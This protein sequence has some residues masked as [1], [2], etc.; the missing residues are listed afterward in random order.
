MSKYIKYDSD[1]KKMIIET[2]NPNL[3]PELNIPRTITL[4]W[5]EKADNF[6]FLDN[7]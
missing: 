7:F 3:Y 2:R 4:Y 6:P 1:I 5:I